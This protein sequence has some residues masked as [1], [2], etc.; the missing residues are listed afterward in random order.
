MAAWRIGESD[1]FVFYDRLFN[2][3]TARVSPDGIVGFQRVIGPSADE[4]CGGWTERDSLG[5][6]EEFTTSLLDCGPPH[7]WYREASSWSASMADDPLFTGAVRCV[8]P[9][10]E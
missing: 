9:P 6:L 5:T 2:T 8:A 3:G 4:S 1:A 7:P 10:G